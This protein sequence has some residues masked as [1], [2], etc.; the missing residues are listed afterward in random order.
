MKQILLAD[1]DA[2]VLSALG[3]LVGAGILLHIWGRHELHWFP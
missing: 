3:I 1:M 2:A